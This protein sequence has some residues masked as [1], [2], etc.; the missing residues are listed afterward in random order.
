MS[1]QNR[2]ELVMDIECYRNYFLVNFMA[3]DS[4]KRIS[5]EQYDGKRLDRKTI[6]AILREY[7]IVTFNGM[8][9][10]GPMLALA[11]TGASCEDLKIAS[12]RIINEGLR[13]WQFEQAY[14]CR[15][16]PDTDH[17]DLKEPVPGVQISLK[18]YGARL[19]S[20]RIQ[21]LPIE[22]D[23][24]ITPEQRP[25]LVSY[26][27]NDLDTTKDLLVKATDPKDNIIETRRLLG[28]EFGLDLRSKS[29]AQIAEAVI[30]SEV[31][32]LKGEPIYKQDVTPGTSYKY[33]PPAFIKFQTE[34]LKKKLADILAS[35][36]VVNAKG[37]IDM[38]P[39]L[40]AKPSKT[41]GVDDDGSTVEIIT[42]P[43]SKV[44]VGASTYSM[45]IGGLHSME[46]RKAH[47]ATSYTLLRDVDVVSFYPAL[48]LLCG[49]FPRNMGELFQQVYSKFFHRRVAAKKS[50]NKS[51]AQTL[52]I[53]LNG[54]FG[55]LGSKWSVLYA[56]DLLIQ[57][58]VTGQLALLML[59]ERFELAGIPVISANTD[60]VVTACPVHLE[61]T[62]KAIV[63]QWERDT[64]LETEETRYRA[65]YSRDVNNY[66]ALS[67]D[68]K[69]KPKVKGV[70]VPP[71]VQK[72]P[73]NE[74][75]SE[76]VVAFLDRGV[77]VGETILRCADIRK[78]LRV[79]RVTG[80]AQIPT[81][82]R[83]VD[84]WHFVRAECKWEVSVNGKVYSE[85]R[86]SRPAPLVVTSSA[87]HLGRVVRWYRS[88]TSTTC[89]EYVKN[90]NKVGGSDNARAVMTLPDRIPEDLDYGFYI[91]EANDLL[92][93]LGARRG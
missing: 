68:G 3:V 36:F 77:P 26:C 92:T 41:V 66:L 93:E 90:G 60:G 61:E 85:R 81:G 46:K 17:I 44:T 51:L 82:T 1:K 88:R 55:K 65:L 48:I 30:K 50:G 58:T 91:D 38:P 83:V 34:T 62:R 7:T 19:H 86:K 13:G 53:V 80:G 21:D 10:D 52:K 20:K 74:I 27:D 15:L 33:K 89:I 16:P 73:D 31:S 49:L 37:K 29:D 75:V 28:L 11:L 45:G 18:L 72:N 39:A 43:S 9:Y 47:I 5:F 70:L 67:E 2:R 64:G 56:P 32:R 84:D 54:T 63:K 4:G 14:G 22:H 25:V 59:I 24:L 8:D 87:E 40:S 76:A 12:D 6:V 79:K 23:A 69:G 71:G 35:N 78:F 57:V 42:P